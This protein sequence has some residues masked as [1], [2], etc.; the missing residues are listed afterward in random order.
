MRQS[1]A[2]HAFGARIGMA[3]PRAVNSRLRHE[4]EDAASAERELGHPW[5]VQRRRRGEHLRVEPGARGLVTHVQ[6]HVGAFDGGHDPRPPRAT[7]LREE[8]PA[9]AAR[10]LARRFMRAHAT[11][12]RAR[13]RGR[14]AAAWSLRGARAPPGRGRGARR[15]GHGR[16]RVGRRARRRGHGRDRVGRR[17]RRRGHGRD[18]V[19]RR[20]LDALS[21]GAALDGRRSARRGARPATRRPDAGARPPGGA[22]REITP[23][24]FWAH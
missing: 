23:M 6:D 1:S 14:S 4:A 9:R 24:P 3:S 16:D 11:T 12:R 18:R 7:P 19:G 5:D 15:R 2:R 13:L 20:A 22:K 17:A 21:V 8:L 10:D